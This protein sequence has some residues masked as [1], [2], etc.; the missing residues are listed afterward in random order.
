MLG[1]A[2]VTVECKN[3]YSDP[4][5]TAADVCDGNLDGA[6]QTT[7]TVNTEVPGVY[8]VRYNVRDASGN[9]ATEITRTV[10]VR[11]SSA[12]TI[13]RLGE[14]TVLVECHTAYTD[15]GAT[16]ADACAGDLTEQ[17]QVSGTVNVNTPGTYTLRYDV[18]DASGNAAVPRSRSVIVRDSTNPQITLTGS[19]EMTVECGN[20]FVEPG[21]T[22]ADAC[23]GDL[24]EQIVFTGA[25]NTQN[26]GAYTL[27][28]SVQDAAGR[29]TQATRTV[30]VT[31]T[32]AP[33]VNLTGG[34][35]VT[36]SCG[37]IYI[38]AGATAVDACDGVLAAT[39][40]DT[41]DSYVPGD[42]ILHFT[43]EDRAG[44]VGTANRVVHVSE[45]AEGEGG[46]PNTLAQCLEQCEGAPWV[47]DDGDGLSACVETCLGFSDAT[48]DSDG[49]GIPDN[50]EAR[51]MDNAEARTPCGDPDHD[52]L[53]NL[54]EYLLNSDPLDPD[55]PDRSYYISPQGEDVTAAGTLTR[56]WAT[57]NYALSRFM[58]PS[59]SQA[60]P[61]S[62]PSA[63]RP[64]RLIVMPGVYQENILMLPYLRLVGQ[65]DPCTETPE[66]PPVTILGWITG[67]N[68]SALYNL[69]IEAVGDADVLLDIENVAMKVSGVAFRG[70]SRRA[71][72]GIL[73]NDGTPRRSV[74]EQCTFTSLAIGIDIWGAVP[75]VRR[76]L[77]E[78]ISQAAILVRANPGV[79]VDPLGN[80]EDPETGWNTFKN[81]VNPGGPAV[82]NQ[83]AGL[84]LLMQKCDWDTNNPAVI[85][86]RVEGNVNTTA[87]LASGSGI[88]AASLYCTVWNAANQNPIL[89]A[90][91]EL[92]PSN[93]FEITNNVGG[94]Y[95]FPAIPSGAYT[96]LVTAPGYA[97]N[98]QPTQVGS[99]QMVSVV[100][101]LWAEMGEG[102]GPVEGGAEGEGGGEGEG[103][104]DCG[105]NKNK[106][107]TM[108]GYGDLF[109][110]GLGLI[111]LLVS[112]ALYRREE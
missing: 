89:N 64:V 41:V 16:A 97:E 50:V 9:A 110:A 17:I 103:E 19:A 66:E 30:T 51:N 74:I 85:A 33:V 35:S 1:N 63:A 29:T 46:A 3:G 45:C 106:L 93:F 48:A 81:S 18:Q 31:D 76:C 111:T 102:E 57:I 25:V 44:N 11:D 52:S 7:G 98:S 61:L 34:N 40:E 68:P 39:T 107:G 10:T 94:V 53:T 80:Q 12:P 100:V 38:D 23:S 62:P 26:P 58:P 36:I 43:A 77:F 101:P 5:A 84:E 75:R 79:P 59:P 91:V 71:A 99:G 104:D 88:L 108:P 112:S 15:A 90:S 24:T 54:E 92:T 86:N 65:L 32:R 83:R 20:V 72:T 27:R 67:A 109:L 95:A 78:D 13:T 56:P 87:Y 96:V 55:D 4:G 73:I 2:T 21:V 82:V 22:A 37:T 8:T 49:N 69:A 42:H 28:Y 6:V 47:D 70:T 60:P 14:A 105:C